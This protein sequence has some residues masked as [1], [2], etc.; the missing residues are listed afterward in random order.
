MYQELIKI[1]LVED[2]PGDAF[3]IQESLREGHLMQF[4]VTQVEQ[5]QEAF[6][7]LNHQDFD[8]ILLDLF[9]PD[10]QGLNTFTEILPKANHLPIVVLT[11]LN[12][13]EMAIQ[14]VRLGAQDYLKKDLVIGDLL[15]Y[16]LCYAIER[17]R[18][19][20]QLEQQKIQLESANAELEKRTEQLEFLNAELEAFSYTVSHDL[21]SPLLSIDGFSFFLEKEYSNQLN[22]KGISYLQRIRSAVQRMDKLIDNLLK[23]SQVQKNKMSIQKVNLSEIVQDTYQELKQ[24]YPQRNV[25][26]LITPN[27]I[28]KGDRQ[29]L[30]VALENLIINAWKYTAKEP[31]AKIEFGLVPD[32]HILDAER[33]IKSKFFSTHP[34][35]PHQTIPR[36]YFVK[37][38]GVGFDMSQVDQLFK[39]FQRLDSSKE[40]PGTGVGLATVQRIIQRHQGR[41]WAESIQ[42][43][44][45]IFYFTLNLNKE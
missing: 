14:S 20:E 28:D 19:Q 16:S 30:K 22:S 29:L 34:T 38:N 11:G 27:L 44:G 21:R 1:L 35:P 32:P 37:D 2:N 17:K 10:S 33:Q 25:N 40:F 8:I 18:T 42:G 36:I 31:T 9:L 41:I 6:L 45:T 4:K 23:L 24:Q 5:L 7:A 3:L 15:V 12:D 39:P 13:E 26:L 43:Q